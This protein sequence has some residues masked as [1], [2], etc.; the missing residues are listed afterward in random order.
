MEKFNQATQVVLQR[1]LA[2]FEAQE[3]Y[4][5]AVRN[6]NQAVADTLG[7]VDA[8]LKKQAAGKATP[9]QEKKAK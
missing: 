3:N 5:A 2:M 4:L 9:A 8:E 6:Y 1:K 7:Y